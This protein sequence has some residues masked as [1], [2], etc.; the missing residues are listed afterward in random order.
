MKII[1][2]P[3]INQLYL[4]TARWVLRKLSREVIN[5]LNTYKVE[6]WADFGTL[7]GI[8]RDQD[9]I[10]GDT[11]V[12]LSIIET[13]ENIEKLDYCTQLKFRWFNLKRDENR[14]SY[15]AYFKWLPARA[16][17]Y[18]YRLNAKK[19]MYEGCEGP[20]SDIPVELFKKIDYIQW[21]LLN[22]S[23]PINYAEFL[24]YRYGKNWMIPKWNDKGRLHSTYYPQNDEEKQLRDT[25]IN[26]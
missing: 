15:T 12:D 1:R 5:M 23:I 6:Y 14:R 21:G 3:I 16:D 4:K 20:F 9:I 26:W 22:V 17:I 7:L 25:N 8:V 11:D 10:L 18:V 13:P 19:E 2:L 24:T